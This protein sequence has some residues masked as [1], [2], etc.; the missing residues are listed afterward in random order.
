[1]EIDRGLFNFF[2][3]KNNKNK[4]YDVLFASDLEI[5]FS[6]RKEIPMFLE[7]LLKKIHPCRALHLRLLLNEQSNLPLDCKCRLDELVTLCIVY[8]C[9]AYE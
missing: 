7:I 1:M 6:L 9:C 8:I 3:R 5:F 2:F 4:Q